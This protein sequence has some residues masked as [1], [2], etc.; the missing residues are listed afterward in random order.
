MIFVLHC[1]EKGKGSREI[2]SLHTRSETLS[3]EAKKIFISNENF[4]FKMIL[5]VSS[6]FVIL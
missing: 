3:F 1:W 2:F 5:K 6:N 4:N